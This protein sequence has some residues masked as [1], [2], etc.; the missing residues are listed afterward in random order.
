MLTRRSDRIETSASCTSG[1]QRVI[2]STRAT[3]PVRI[4]VS[5]GE[6]TSASAV[7]PCASSSA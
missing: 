2:S 7:G 4:A 3:R 6:S 1:R 5:T